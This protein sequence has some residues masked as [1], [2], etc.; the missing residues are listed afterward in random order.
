MF[1]LFLFLF[2]FSFFVLFL[3]HHSM[4]CISLT[5][6]LTCLL[7]MEASEFTLESIIKLCERDQC[8]AAQYVV[9]TLAG[10]LSLRGQQEDNMLSLYF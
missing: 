4:S 2:L 8:L 9:V 1:Y 5:F 6:I 3:L 7:F 10:Q